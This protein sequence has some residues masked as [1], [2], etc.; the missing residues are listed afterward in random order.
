M[1]RIVRTLI[2]FLFVT[3]FAENVGSTGIR[4]NVIRFAIF[5]EIVLSVLSDLNG[6]S[7][8][9]REKILHVSGCHCIP[10]SY[11][12]NAFYERGLNV[13]FH[14]TIPHLWYEQ[15]NGRAHATESRNVH[16]AL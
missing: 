15:D 8:C 10:D 13:Q 14:A 2:D 3:I 16:I 12:I 1:S 4:Y 11:K 5:Y 7:T 6:A 9:T